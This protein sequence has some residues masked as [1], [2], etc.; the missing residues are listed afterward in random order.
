MEPDS[1]LEEGKRILSPKL[2]PL[3]YRFELIRRPVQGSGRPF[4]IAAFRRGDRSVRMWARFE[5]L[6]VD[7]VVGDVEFTHT[8]H[9]RALGFKDSAQFPGFNEGDS[10]DAFRRLLCDLEHCTEFLA[11]DAQAIAERVRSLPPEKT[12]FAA[13][14]S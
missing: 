10:L 9:M 1:F 2:E 12:G 6:R 14:G 4:A 3:G 11:G 13:L 5:N 7:Y 8:D